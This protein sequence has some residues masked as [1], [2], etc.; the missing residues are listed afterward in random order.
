MVRLPLKGVFEAIRSITWV[1]L[2]KTCRVTFNLLYLRLKSKTLSVLCPGYLTK[3]KLLADEQKTQKDKQRS[4]DDRIRREV[5]ISE[6][7][8]RGIA[9][10]PN[11]P[12]ATAISTDRR[13]ARPRY[14]E[15]IKV[16]TTVAKE[17]IWGFHKS[18]AYGT[19]KISEV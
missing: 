18:N 10:D 16:D 8:R 2:F 1:L 4:K 6:Q 5:K 9:V 15:P 13:R 19:T 14:T 17:I 11:K 7:V 3:L 12:F